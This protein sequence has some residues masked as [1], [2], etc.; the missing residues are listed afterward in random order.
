VNDMAGKG[1]RR[2]EILNRGGEGRGGIIWTGGLQLPFDF[3]ALSISAVVRIGLPLTAGYLF[4]KKKTLLHTQDHLFFFGCQRN[5]LTR[6]HPQFSY[7]F[8][9]LIT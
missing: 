2:S 9:C 3:R 1:A 6:S 5:S 8:L 4:S 7:D